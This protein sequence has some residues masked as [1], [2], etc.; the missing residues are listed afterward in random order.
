MH[1]DVTLPTRANDSALGIKPK[2]PKQPAI[3]PAQITTLVLNGTTIVGLARDT[4]YKLAQAGFHTV[5]LPASRHGRHTDADVLCELRL[6]RLG[7]GER[8][9][10][11][12]SG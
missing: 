2:P 9:G 5:Q 8:A 1:P 4:S 7:A 11:R 10:G 6:L 3:K 12:R